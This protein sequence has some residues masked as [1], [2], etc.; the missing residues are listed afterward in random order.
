MAQAKGQAWRRSAW[1]G[2]GELKALL[3]AI[4][5][6]PLAAHAVEPDKAK[7]AGVS[8][9]IAAALTVACRDTEHPVLYALM[10]TLGVGLAKELYDSRSGGSGFSRADLGA[11]AVGAAVGAG[12]T[13]LIIGPAFLGWQMKF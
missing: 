2:A 12:T 5:L 9:A 6:L 7:H 1:S 8:A 3:F 11:D 4:L 13:G 10:G